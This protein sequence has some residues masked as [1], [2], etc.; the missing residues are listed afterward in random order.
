M[1]RPMILSTATLALLAFGLACNNSTRTVSGGSPETEADTKPI[2]AALISGPKELPPP[3]KPPTFSSEPIL[4]PAHL[5]VVDKRDVPSQRDS[6]ILFIGTEVVDPRTAPEKDKLFKHREKFYRE[7]EPGQRVEL[8]QVIML[9]D[10]REAFAALQASFVLAE[11]SKKMFLMSTEVRQTTEQIYER[12]KKLWDNGKQI[13]ELEYIQA[14]IELARAR[15]TEVNQEADMKK[16]QEEYNKARINHEYFI[17][18]AP[19]AG[20]IQPF[21]RSPGEAVKAL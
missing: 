6:K 4:I 19:V 9:L 2:G 7:L 10:D 11:S 8:D 5:T 16:A 14:E 1:L 18:R 20:S 3:A 15:A 12:R 13:S 21:T 17:I